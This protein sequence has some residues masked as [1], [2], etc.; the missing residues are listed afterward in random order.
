MSEREVWT[1]VAHKDGMFAGAISGSLDT[2]ERKA[3]PAEAKKW[4]KEIAKFCG[5]FIADGFL[6]T[7]TYSMA[8]A[9]TLMK[10]MPIWK[11]PEKVTPRCADTPDLFAAERGG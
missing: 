11:R 2:P 3:T 5:D 6:I 10:G 8:E 9:D 7:P 1:Y 4:K